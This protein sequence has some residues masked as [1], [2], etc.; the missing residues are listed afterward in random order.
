MNLIGIFPLKSVVEIILFASIWSI[1]HAFIAIF[2][3]NCY[4]EIYFVGCWFP[5]L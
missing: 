1:E 5:V 3:Y 2:A 4:P